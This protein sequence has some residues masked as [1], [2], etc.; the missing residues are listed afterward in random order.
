MVVV[1]H[2]GTT[3]LWLYLYSTKK[4]LLVHLSFVSVTVDFLRKG[5]IHILYLSK[6]K[7]SCVNALM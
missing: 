7:K 6:I 4:Q 3:S 5:N 2:T 1:I